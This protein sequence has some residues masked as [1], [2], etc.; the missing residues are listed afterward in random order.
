MVIYIEHFRRKTTTGDVRLTSTPQ[1]QIN[2]DKIIIENMTVFLE[3]LNLPS[4]LN[5][6]ILGRLLL[7]IL[8]VVFSRWQHNKSDKRINV[9]G[10][11]YPIITIIFR[12]QSRQ[13]S[14][15][16][17]A[18]LPDPSAQYRDSLSWCLYPRDDIR[19][20]KLLA[21]LVFPGWGSQRGNEEIT[22]LLFSSCNNGQQ[23][24]LFFPEQ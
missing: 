16:Y 4:Y 22:L 10:I 24:G 3:N 18:R 23:T 17:R 1:V 9:Q 20:W 7:K 11:S 13:W 6:S 8:T 5:I 21:R 12:P 19:E 2:Y 15:H 14:E